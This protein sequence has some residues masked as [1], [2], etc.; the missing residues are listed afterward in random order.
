MK[1]F[2][3]D[4]NLELYKAFYYVASTLNF[5]EASRQLYISQSA[6]SQA[7]KQ[8]EQKLGH[9]LFIRSTK[10]VQL[11]SEG[12]LLFQHV[13]P[14]M[15]M[16]QDGEALFTG[17]QMPVEQIRIAASDT[18]CRYFLLPYFHRFHQ[19]FPHIRI[20]VINSTSIGCLEL[21]DSGQ[22]ELVVCNFPNSRLQ[23]HMQTKVLLDFKDIFIAEQHFFDKKKKPETLEELLEYPLLMLSANSATHEYLQQMFAAKNLKLF[24]EVE[25][26][27]NDLL[28]DLAKISLGI[29]CVPDYM[30]N[31]QESLL[32]IQIK[33][34]LPKRQLILVSHKNLPLSSA[35]EKFA[36]YL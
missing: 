28:M 14:A 11:T 34:S 21:L 17:N 3:M 8:L 5:S 19:E 20:K 33:E 26:N 24:P 6:V 30:L 27:S 25:L 7:I 1:G 23:S 36:Q 4:I 35:A 31:E 13:K 12:E 22:A 29:A 9:P 2:S 10:K 16:L 15:R 32:P 18:I